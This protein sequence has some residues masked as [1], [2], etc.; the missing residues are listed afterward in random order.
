MSANALPSTHVASTIAK[1][2]VLVL[3]A[4]WGLRSPL[5]LDV[6][7]TVRAGALFATIML[8]A[9]RF[10]PGHHPFPHFG[11]ANQVTTIRAALASI[12]AGLIGAP[13]TALVANT[14]VGIATVAAVLAGVDG[15]LARRSGM[16]SQFGGRFDMEIDALLIMVL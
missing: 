14:A 7:T 8:L 1:G 5:Q 3:A 2:L 16:S 13:E 12:I 15:C 10:L 11:A 4:A 9:I 6:L